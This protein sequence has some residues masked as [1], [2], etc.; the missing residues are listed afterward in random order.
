ML[1]KIFILATLAA[2]VLPMGA[3]QASKPSWEVA[4]ASQVWNHGNYRVSK[5]ALPPIVDGPFNLGDNVIIQTVAKTC[6]VPACG[7]RDAWILRN[8]SVMRVPNVPKGVLS[9]EKYLKNDGRVL[10]AVA[11][12]DDAN[13]F[14]VVELDL[15]SGQK[16]TR[17]SG[18]FLDGVES[19]DVIAA[20]D[21]IFLNPIFSFDEPNRTFKEAAVFRYAPERDGVV[22]VTKR[23]NMQHEELLDVDMVNRRILTKMTFPSGDKELFLTKLDSTYYP[24]GES[25]RVISTYTPKHEDIV[26][27]HFRT[28]GAIEYFRFFDRTITTTDRGVNTVRTASMNEKLNWDRPE[29]TSLFVDGDSMVYVNLDGVLTISNASTGVIHAG[30]V[31][32]NVVRVNEDQVFYVTKDGQGHVYDLRN[33]NTVSVAF[34]PS[35]RFGHGVVGADARGKVQ[36]TNIETN[37]NVEL[38]FGTNV[39]L[40]D[41]RHIYWRGVDGGV[42][43]ATIA[44]AP[45][46]IGNYQI[47][48]VKI[49]DSSVVYLVD[50]INRWAFP[51]EEV[52]GTWFENWDAV[53]TVSPMYLT[54]FRDRG[55]A[56]YAPG[57]RMKAE[58]DARVYV[59]GR[60][61]K[62]HWIVNEETAMSVYGP[63]WN[64]G[65][66]QVPMSTMVS[67]KLGEAIESVTDWQVL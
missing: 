54:R 10:W 26:G 20:G 38:G 8:G 51:S 63:V 35:D 45:E 19:M 39:A 34:I 9:L 16:I 17:A 27:A 48:A 5:L 14:D 28:D 44:S 6:P 21:E 64:K 13:V 46:R 23:Y 49:A 40:S 65:I 56:T 57:T 18:I 25:D 29:G 62:A 55:P 47:E 22:L 50:G 41:D 36:Y 12:P 42:Y 52:F 3:I 33:G 30:D 37:T 59:L 15:V 7:E 58:G 53:K 43:E 60:D 11:M 66:I 2:L 31:D 67:Y 24:Y 32:K 1:K 4:N 61:G